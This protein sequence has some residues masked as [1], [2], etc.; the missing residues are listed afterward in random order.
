MEIFGFPIANLTPGVVLV[1]DG[2][3]WCKTDLYRFQIARDNLDLDITDRA[4]VTV[5]L[6]PESIKAEPV[7]DDA[8]MAAEVF[9]RED[10]GAEEIIYID[11]NGV[12][13][14]MVR[15][16]VDQQSYEQGESI[17]IGFES[18]ALFVFDAE[19]GNRIGKGKG[20][21]HV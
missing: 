2:Q 17:V 16:A 3:L 5:G 14:T 4:K 21:I 11:I 19:N 6:R 10:L 8:S 1:E 18:N 15:T 20:T 12:E 9:L 7:D 13:W